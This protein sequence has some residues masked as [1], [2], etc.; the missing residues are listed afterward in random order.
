MTTNHFYRNIGTTEKQLVTEKNA[1]K[2][3]LPKKRLTVDQIFPNNYVVIHTQWGKGL[4]TNS[5]MSENVILN[6]NHIFSSDPS[7]MLGL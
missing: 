4:L 1:Y 7:A 5:F 3:A 6:I 2:C